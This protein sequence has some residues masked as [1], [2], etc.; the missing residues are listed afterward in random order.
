MC[1]IMEKLRDEA[2]N[3][4]KLETLFDLVKDGMLSIAEA[5]RR[6]DMTE[7]IFTENMKRFNL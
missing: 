4:G 6:A 2:K 3:E 5:A 7:S 1:E